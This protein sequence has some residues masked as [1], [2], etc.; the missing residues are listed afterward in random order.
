M[1]LSGVDWWDFAASGN[2]STIIPLNQIKLRSISAMGKYRTGRIC[3]CC[4]LILQFWCRPAEPGYD[5]LS[6]WAVGRNTTSEVCFNDQNF[7]Y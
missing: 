3:L 7:E 6:F 1:A 4:I 2:F 5:E